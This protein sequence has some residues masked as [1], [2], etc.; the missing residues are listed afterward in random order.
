M[1]T[2][3]QCLILF[4]AFLSFLRLMLGAYVLSFVCCEWPFI[5]IIIIIVLTSKLG[6]MPFR[7]IGLLLLFKIKIKG[8]YAS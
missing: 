1:L 4:N 8:Q 3:E 6:G 2:C 5:I 7:M